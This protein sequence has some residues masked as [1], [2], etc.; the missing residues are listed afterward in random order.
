MQHLKIR[1][2][3]V[4]CHY[5]GI[6]FSKPSTYCHTLQYLI[7]FSRMKNNHVAV[8][9]GATERFMKNFGQKF[10]LQVIVSRSNRNIILFSINSMFLYML[11]AGIVMSFLCYLMLFINVTSILSPFLHF[12][13]RVRCYYIINMFFNASVLRF[14]LFGSKS[15]S[16]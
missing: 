7:G 12:L 2:R 15:R 8:N 11:D 10:F 16:H 3:F 13:S 1:S 9:S 5:N 14:V 6:V 4:Y